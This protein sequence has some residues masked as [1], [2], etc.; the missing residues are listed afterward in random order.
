[1]VSVGRVVFVVVWVRCRFLIWVFTMVFLRSVG[2]VGGR[3]I[4]GFGLFGVNF[5]CVEIAFYFG[6]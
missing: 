5:S 1:M 4:D 6:V 3:G 2:V